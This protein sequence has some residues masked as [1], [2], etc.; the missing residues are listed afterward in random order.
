M[1]G[2]PG[3]EWLDSLSPDDRAALL[4]EVKTQ[5]S[6]EALADYRPYAKQRQFHELGKTMRERLLRAGNQCGKSY[7]VGNE[8]AMHL[9]GEYPAWWKGR[10]WTR[11]VVAWASGET[12]EATRDNPQRILLGRVDEEGTGTIPAR[13]F[14]TYGMA[15]GTAKLFDYLKVRHK[16]GGWSLLRF[17]YYAQGQ[18]KWQG[19]PVD[20]VWFDEEPPE[21]I[22]DEGLARTIA[23]NGMAAMSFTPLKGMSTVVRR[24]LMNPTPDRADVNMTIDDAEHIS[25]EQRAI[26][27]ASFPAHEREARAKGVPTLGQGRVWP[28]EDALLEVDPFPIPK[29]WARLCAIDFGYDHP[30][31]AVWLAF[32]RDTGT[33]YVTD[34]YRIKQAT[35]ATHVD[36]MKPRCGGEGNLWMPVAWPHDGHQH[37]KGS[38]I[39]LQRQYRDRGLNMLP[40][41]AQHA[42]DG[43][44]EETKAVRQSVEA[45]VVAMYDEMQAGR[46]KVFRH[47]SDWF[48]EFRLYHR[49]DGKIVALNDDL[50][51]ATRY[52]W[53]SRDY[54]MVP[55]VEETQRKPT[56]QYNW[57]TM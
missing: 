32:D 36:A 2:T 57:R 7:C 39:V 25:P 17:K 49:E 35:P 34:C 47:L 1:M 30:F 56:R 44:P 29:H 50:M 55:P 9:T 43:T 22:Y 16:S 54:A 5:L 28:F 42:P 23:T 48:E 12:G 3:L 18:A 4:A 8:W 37:E 51:S 53:M 19:P 33:M 31:A 15:A 11:P 6:R 45:G 52:G 40:M 41:H 46:I 14:G 27:I 20:L 13:C 21:D 24:F 38:G 10:R 26:V